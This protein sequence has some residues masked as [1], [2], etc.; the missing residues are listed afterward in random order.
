MR[1]LKEKKILTKMG[2]FPLLLLII[3]LFA[4]T[5]CE[6]DNFNNVID[7]ENTE[8]SK[9]VPGNSGL[10]NISGVATSSLKLDWVPATDNN[11]DSNTLQYRIV[12]VNLADIDTLV[13]TDDYGEVVMDWTSNVKSVIIAGLSPG[14]TVYFNVQVRDR[15]GLMSAYLPASVTTST[16]GSSGD[17][18]PVSIYS[19]GTGTGDLVSPLT[20]SAR[21]DLDAICT[22]ANPGLTCGNIRAFISLSGSDCIKNFTAN[23]NVPAKGEI[24]STTGKILGYRWADILD[25]TVNM[26]LLNAGIA[27]QSWWSGSNADGSFNSAN[28]CNNWTDGTSGY[29][30]LA[31]EQNEIDGEWIA[32]TTRN[33]NNS[34]EL[35][36][37]CW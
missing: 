34:L 5:G 1:K 14:E 35:L 8:A 36:C 2:V 15:D 26:N 31:G 18:D 22:A 32:G 13:G 4:V 20:S 7:R 12:K 17:S 9:P 24:I 19:A 29:Q 10:L 27:S 6:G 21:S 28:T 25:G 16:D 33:C 30:G 3:A 23:Y 37:I 11:T